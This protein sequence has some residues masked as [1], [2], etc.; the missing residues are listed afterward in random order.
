MP[1]ITKITVQKNG[2][3]YNIYLKIGEKEIFG[4]SVDQDVLI[5]WQLKRGMELTEDEIAKIKADDEVKKAYHQSL[6]YLSYRMRSKKEIDNYLHKK[7]Y[8]QETIK[9][10]IKKLSSYDFV[11][12]AMFAEMFVQAKIQTSMK[13]P[14]LL[15]QQ[16]SQKGIDQHI[17]DETLDQFSFEEQV[18]NAVKIIEKK[19]PS[20]KKYSTKQ[21][22]NKLAQYLLS[23]GYSYSVIESAFSKHPV[24]SVDET[25]W[26]A[27]QYQGKKGEKKFSH[28]SGHEFERK[29]KQ[30]LFQK[31]F[32]LSLIEKY[33]ETYTND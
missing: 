6:Q 12:D 18:K 7:G 33:L 5:E 23:K 17:I 9:K 10:V 19:L 30:W 31:G 29:M 32:S 21:K 20:L 13:G 24:K 26:E 3:R 27:I 1:V 2:E 8:S 16:L 11:N 14:A 4:F 25:E 22:Q 15:K 28:L